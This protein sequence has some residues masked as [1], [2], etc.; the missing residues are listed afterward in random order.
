MIQHIA[1]FVHGLDLSDNHCK[2]IFPTQCLRFNSLKWLT[3]NRMELR[4]IPFDIRLLKMLESIQLAD[5]KLKT[6]K[7][8][9]VDMPYLCTLVLRSNELHTNSFSSDLKTPN[10][11][12]LVN[13]K[14]YLSIDST[15]F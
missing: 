4:D 2:G 13:L 15:F 5:N 10:L 9:L 14:P 11:A 8:R 3:V 6:M 7:N 12:V 1:K